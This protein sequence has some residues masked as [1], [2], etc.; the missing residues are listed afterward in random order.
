MP[1]EDSKNLPDWSE[2]QL[3]SDCESTSCRVIDGAGC[4]EVCQRKFIYTL[5]K[6]KN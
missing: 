5:K 4:E 1:F 3:D 6:A 2:C